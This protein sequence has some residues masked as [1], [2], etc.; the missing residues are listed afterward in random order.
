MARY[1][2][3]RHAFAVPVVSLLLGSALTVK[4]VIRL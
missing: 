2:R 3:W 1:V 4:E